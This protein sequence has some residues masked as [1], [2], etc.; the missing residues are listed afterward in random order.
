ME[1]QRIKS[2]TKSC[3]RLLILSVLL[4]AIFPA[5][6]SAQKI[7]SSFFKNL[8][9]EPSPDQDLFTNTSLKFEVIIPEIKPGQIEAAVPSEGENISFRTLRRLEDFTTGGTKIELWMSFSK[10]GTYKLNPLQVK[11]KNN[12]YNIKFAD[13]VIRKNPQELVPVVF[14][15]LNGTYVN[16]ETYSAG[17]KAAPIIS[18]RAGQKIDFRIYIKYAVQLVQ[19][20]W[21]IPKNSIFTEY[22]K[23]E[24]T[25]LKYRDRVYSEDLVPI[26]DFEWIPL[27]EGKQELPEFSLSAIGYNGRRT[28]LSMPKAYI[29]VNAGASS[30]GN[31]AGASGNHASQS[32]LFDSAFEVNRDEEEAENAKVVTEEVCR[33]LAELR[34]RERIFFTIKTIRHREALEREYNIPV[35]RKEFPAV[36]LI[37]SI[38]FVLLLIILLLIFIRKRKVGLAICHGVTLICFLVIMIVSSVKVHSRFAIS[39]GCTLYTIPEENAQTKS[40]LPA[41]NRVQIRDEAADWYYVELGESVG[42]CRKNEVLIIK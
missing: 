9:I 6:L 15:R 37:I 16:S 13:F 19:Y 2:D 42:W 29:Q 5:R 28:D 34:G 31:F 12:S 39:L 20:D 17:A 33:Q 21:E 38:F 11:V 41:G 40:Q 8:R 23:Y 26:A 10:D 18:V 32:R 3:R 24:I 27:V 7:N 35:S 4:L 25:E 36:I 22:K 14:V 30:T 1:K